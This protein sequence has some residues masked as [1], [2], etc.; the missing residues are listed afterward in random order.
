MSVTPCPRPTAHICL[1]SFATS[2]LLCCVFAHKHVL[3][4]SLATRSHPRTMVGWKCIHCR[5]ARTSLASHFFA[6]TRAWNLQLGKNWR[7]KG[8]KSGVKWTNGSFSCQDLVG[9]VN[10]ESLRLFF[11]TKTIQ[12][13]KLWLLWY[14]NINVVSNIYF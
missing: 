6:K 3:R 9:L 8:T 1:P 11:V 10:F 14:K 13:I 12:R 5:S 7:K 2:F 4:F